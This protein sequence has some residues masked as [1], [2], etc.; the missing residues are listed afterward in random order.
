MTAAQ[1]Q[2]VKDV[3]ADAL[4]R[5]A[6]D[7][8]AFLAG[9]CS[10]DPLVYREAQRLIS[11]AADSSDSFL[12]DP[13]LPLRHLLQQHSLPGPYFSAGQMVAGRFEILQFLNRGGMGEVYSAMDLELREKVALKTIRPAI[14]SSP[15]VIGR[16]KQEVRQARRI[17]HTNVCHV[18]DLFSHEPPS[19]KPVWFLTMELLEGIT[20]AEQIAG[21]G[22][23]TMDKA[24]PLIRDM[25]NALSAAHDLGI[26]HRDFKPN[27][28]MLV[29]AGPETERA[30]VTDFGLAQ[31]VNS[32]LKDTAGTPAYIAPEQAAG[33]VIDP[34]ADQFS[35]GLVIAEIL[36]G[37]P[38]KLDRSAP[39]EAKQQLESWLSSQRHVLNSRARATISRCLAFRPEKRF[40]HVRDV[41]S[42]LDGSRDTIWK[43]RALAGALAAL[44]VTAVLA[45][46]AL[47]GGD[48][49]VNNV[50]RLTPETD[51]SNSPS[52][53]RDGKWVVY[54][55]NRAETGNSDIW[56][57]ST[58]GGAAR[59]LTT[60]PAADTDPSLSPDGRQVAFRSERENSGIYV[61]G[62]DGSNERLL[63]PG[64]RSPI[65]SPDGRFIAFWIGDPDD[66]APSGELYITSLA[67][68]SPRRLAA[69]FIDARYPAWSP[70]GRFLV[71]EGCRAEFGPFPACTDLWISHADGPGS[72][73]T[74]AMPLLEADKI[75]LYPHQKVWRGDDIL[76]SGKRGTGIDA[77]W[78]L[79][80][81][82]TTMRVVGKPRQLTLG[83][84]R[85]HE[86][87]VAANGT[88]AFSRLSGALHTW[89]I[90]LDASGE[91]ARASKLTDAPIGECCP[92][93]S[94][95]G[96]Y[97]FFTRRI[98]TVKDLFRKDLTTGAD[99]VLLMSPEEKSWPVPDVDGKK[100]AF[101]SR[102]EQ[103]SSIELLVQDQPLRKLCVGCSHPTS[104]FGDHEIFH[105]SPKGGIALLNVDTGVSRTVL[106]GTA[107]MTLGE[108]DWNPDNEYLLFAASTNGATKQVF[109]VQFPESGGAAE[110][111]WV[112]LTP[113]PQMAERPRWSNGGKMFF[114]LSNRD[115]YLCVWGQR[116]VPR[117]TSLEKPFPVFHY[118][119][120]PRFSPNRADPASRGFSVADNSIFLNVGES[121]ETVWVGMLGP[122]SI[123]SFLRD[124]LI[125]RV[126]R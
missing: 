64:G 66:S 67:G 92:S 68:G 27:N 57:D 18:Y 105:A 113:Q 13:P 62:A 126:S 85:E 3:T 79:T 107:G 54:A 35:L 84:A 16:F 10:D 95:D 25:V 2:R 40:G 4:E 116:F 55:S 97:L 20:L 110:G 103:E 45:I 52:L 75:D 29:R 121:I 124:R 94:P 102:H 17:A 74:G 53:S 69:D 51:H 60:N 82:R 6:A 9:A 1:W 5:K 30:V 21:A 122:P 44:A 41:L 96:R 119:D 43:R 80:I 63:F 47:A 37:K 76:V 50:L 117:A 87:S 100:V 38:P 58:R 46:A 73:Q 59:R 109:A 61:V 125:A 90:A 70:D 14:A 11:E 36:T 77:L 81:S 86:P 111:P 88:I 31:N 120:Y 118:H 106:S 26:V 42:E 98:Q 104:W 34:A 112:P 83:E 101:E 19:G 115:G 114:Y 28:V 78:A 108:A 8:G 33:G 7:R 22:P 39:A 91:P 65:F 49:R 48:E 56:I 24:L 123:T 93:A 72:V 99:S 23:L 32:E 89:R 12:S 71:F 15:S